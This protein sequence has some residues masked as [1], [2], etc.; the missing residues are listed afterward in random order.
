MMLGLTINALTI[1]RSVGCLPAMCLVI[2]FGIAGCGSGSDQTQEEVAHP[3][4]KSA[5]SHGTERTPTGAVS[6]VAWSLAHRTGPRSIEIISWVGHCAGRP[7]PRIVRVRKRVRHGEFYLTVFVFRPRSDGED[8]NPDPSDLS[9][10][11]LRRYVAA[12]N[13]PG[14]RLALRKTIR[15]NET[16]EGHDL[17][18]EGTV[19]PSARS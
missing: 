12:H 6:P 2:L 18:D 4:K 9:P 5:A 14:V 7:K 1:K 11:E 10:A 13:C 3:P 17:F 15:F 16:I 8:G 19:P